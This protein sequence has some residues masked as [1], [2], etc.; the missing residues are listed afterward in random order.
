MRQSGPASRQ[1]RGPVSSRARR[2][3]SLSPDRPI[4]LRLGVGRV[5]LL[6][7]LAV[8]ALQLLYVQSIAAPALSAQAASQRTTKETEAAVRGPITDRNGN[9]LAFTITAKALHFQPVRVRQQLADAK[10]T[11]PSAPDPEQRLKDIAKFVHD[12]LGAGAPKEEELLDKLRGDK[13]F[14]YLAR[15]VDPRVA[16]EIVAKFPEVGAERQDL[17]E[18]PGGVLAAN[19]VGAT[20]WDG[21]GQIGLESALDSV[22]AG[23]DGSRTYDRGSDGAVIPGSYRDQQPAVNGYGVE[24]TLDEDMQYFVQQQVQQA[25]QQSGAS[26]ASAVVLDAKTGQ[27]LAMANDNTFNPALG[28]QH[29]ASANMSNPSVSEPFEPG[30]VNKIITAAAAIEYG[31]TSP[32][33]VLQVPGSIRMSGVTVNDAWQ[34][35]TAPYTTT[36]IFGKSSNVGTLMLAQR[37]GEDRFADMID[38]FGLGKRTGIGLPGE[39]PGLV[40]ARDQW[41]GGT[42][43]N[44]PIGQGLSMTTLQMTGM[45]QAIANDGL[46]IPPRIVKAKVAPDGT[47][48]EEL[49]PDGV[50]VVSPQTAAT[51]RQIFQATVQKDPMGYQMGTGP[52]AAIEGYQVAGK[53]GTAQK[54]DPACRCYSTS[55]Y[56]IT[57]AGMVPADNPRYVIG[58]MLDAPVRSSDG[59]G[60]GSAAPLFHTIASWALQ[61]DRVP[62][63]PEPKQL[64]LE[65]G[66]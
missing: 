66:L 58:M 46:R 18:Y 64:V 31:L 28:P 40:P 13:T 10:K 1:R 30:S 38:R 17:R 59:T 34:H 65:A 27:V 56:Y 6:A 37:V 19:V 29:W 11:K 32:D 39:S 24:L 57:F 45:Y 14:T 61:R 51:L 49:Q 33:E 44:L 2:T 26:A 48:T 12:K 5:T 9:R 62:P 53:T 22:L 15:N 7:S 41:S 8:V 63:S 43:A 23:T 54:V 4:R 25:K 36:G 50:R 60:G 16:A 42:F 47:R 55:S 21:H 35:G 20:G 3:R 52:Q